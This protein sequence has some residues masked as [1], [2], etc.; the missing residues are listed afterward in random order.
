MIKLNSKKLTKI[1]SVLM[2]VMMILSIACTVFGA[3]PGDF[4]GDESGTGASKAKTIINQVIGMAQVI[5]V[6]VAVIMLIVLAIKY[7]SAAP[8]DKAD[9][10]KSAAIY[11]T[12]AVLLFGA[13]GLLQI[14]KGFG[15]TING[16][17]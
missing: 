7:I 13:S 1:V 6:G 16:T 17:K 3:D 14:V 12:G 5:G 11:I 8:S 4:K 10:K 9:I 2:I 15:D